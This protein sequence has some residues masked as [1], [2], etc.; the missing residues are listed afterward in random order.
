MN[1]YNLVAAREPVLTG[2]RLQLLAAALDNP[3][4]R[5]LILPQLIK[6]G[7][8]ARL[9]SLKLDEPPTHNPRYQAGD[10]PHIPANCDQIAS[11]AVFSSVLNATG[12]CSLRD[13]AQAYR[14]GETTPLKIAGKLLD[15]LEQTDSGEKPMRA[16]VACDREQ[17]LAQ[18]EVATERFAAN[19]SCGIF[20][21]IPVAI[22]DELDVQGYPTRVGTRFLGDEPATED[23]TVVARLRQAGALIVGKTNMHEIGINPRGINL[24]HGTVRNPYNWSRDPGGSSGGSAAAVAAGLCPVAIGADGGGSIRIPAALCG[25]VGLKAT[26]GR[27]S[28]YGSFPL[29]W[30]VG[31]L[32]PIGATVDDVAL[33]YA[34]TAGPDPRDPNTMHQPSHKLTGG[35]SDEAADGLSSLRLGIYPE[36]FNHAESEI[37]ACCEEMVNQLAARGAE[38]V[39]IEIPDLDELRLAHGVTI[40]S[41]MATSMANYPQHWHELSAATRINLSLGRSFSAVDY[42]QAQRMRTRAMDAFANIF[43]GVDVVVSPATAVLAPPISQQ[44]LSHGVA[45]MGVVAELMRFVVPANMTGL[46]AIS[47]PVGYSRAGLPI[48]MQLMGRPWEEQLLFRVARVTESLVSRRLPA[49]YTDL[50]GARAS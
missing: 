2:R 16:F 11:E 1:K 10:H 20:Y 34:A 41:E 22:K 38:I 14:R 15:A 7:G 17:L 45:D 49:G 30:S 25:V 36:W 24:H 12:F 47:L 4:L 48:G 37:V 46:P 39:E 31:H 5:P 40:L 23:A 43:K 13:L 9:R 6:S 26:Y 42:L 18:A 19:Q 28:S 3:V 8:L 44:I 29:D 33:A 21:G 32:G 35:K 50:L 27:I